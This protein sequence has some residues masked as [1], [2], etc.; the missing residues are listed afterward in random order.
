MRLLY[1]A[2]ALA[3]LVQSAKGYVHRARVL[4]PEGQ[5]A[6]RAAAVALCLW[7]V[8]GDGG[9]FARSGRMFFL[10]V[11]VALGFAL[12]FAL[13]GVD[14]KNLWPPEGADISALPAGAVT[15]L[16]LY[17]YGVY[18]LCLPRRQEDGPKAWPWA[19]LG[20]GVLALLL[21]I[22]VGTFGPALAA[23]LGDPFLLLLQG[24]KAPG[25]FRRG[26]AAL[27]AVLVLA[28]F[29]LLALLSRGC[30]GLWSELT[31]PRWAPVGPVLAGAAILTAGL[32][33]AADW[34]RCL[35]V[36][37]LIFGAAVPVLAALLGR[38]R[39]T[40]IFSGT[41]SEGKEDVGE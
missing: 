30:V 4:L 10:A 39:R 3:L 8:R 23:S 7:L 35:P 16:S 21:F 26:E 34:S 31:P 36:G 22:I 38:T 40:A 29:T 11:T 15:C 18:A 25:A 5:W 17:G 13:P 9:V 20:G 32:G 2:W 12:I 33:P 6:A 24:V 14:W 27:T 19:A 1:L 41:K 28:D 37:N